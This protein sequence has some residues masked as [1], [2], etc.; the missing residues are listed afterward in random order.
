VCV[1]GEP[2]GIGVQT[3]P[4][5]ETADT[6]AECDEW[7]FA[8]TEACDFTDHPVDFQVAST[9]TLAESATN[10]KKMTHKDDKVSF[11]I[12]PTNA[13]LM[14]PNIGTTLTYSGWLM[15]SAKIRM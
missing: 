10:V 12:F 3:S 6:I 13:S 14:M 9:R 7:T 15:N 8:F 11:P 5:S 1:E 4:R 2:I